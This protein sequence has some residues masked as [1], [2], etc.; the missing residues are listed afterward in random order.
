MEEKGFLTLKIDNYKAKMHYIL[1]EDKT[2]CITLGSSQKVELIR[3]NKKTQIAYGMLSENFVDTKV[4]VN[5][6]KNLVKEV[7][8]EMSALKHNH[9]KTWN[10]DLVILELIN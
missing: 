2:I 9:Y 6:D 5:E 8:T 10:D 1:R 4:N 3:D 7:F